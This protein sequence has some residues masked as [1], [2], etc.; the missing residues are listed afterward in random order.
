MTVESALSITVIEDNESLRRSLVRILV[1][2]GHNVSGVDSAE[3]FVES[4]QIQDPDLL[5]VDLNLPGEDGLSLTGRM[6]R[7]QPDLGIIILSAR[8]TPSDKQVGYERGADIYLTKPVA[9]GEL[10]AA[11]Y[12]LHRRLTPAVKKFDL[13]ID[14]VHSRVVGPEGVARVSA[15]ELAIMLGLSRAPDRKLEAWQIAEL[16]CQD[17]VMPE[18][19][20]LNVAI[21]RINK[22]LQSVGIPHRGIRS[23]RNW[24]Y[25]LEIDVGVVSQASRID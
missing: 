16:I 3:A 6:R 1:Q 7:L 13:T 2:A 14:P 17:D 25:Q 24:G 11:V 4:R 5:L 22:K 18:R 21:F 12:A 10:K 15:L 9:P 20:A 23:I 8:S 19:N